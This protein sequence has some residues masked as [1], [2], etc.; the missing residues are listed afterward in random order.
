MALRVACAKKYKQ[1]HGQTRQTWLGA[2][3]SCRETEVR[4]VKQEAHNLPLVNL[5]VGMPVNIGSRGSYAIDKLAAVSM[6]LPDDEVLLGSERGKIVRL[7]ASAI[8]VGV[9]GWLGV[10]VCERHMCA[11]TRYVVGICVCTCVISK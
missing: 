3:C 6:V 1:M 8:E 10:R 2:G 9:G 7:L 5:Q 11:F 4:Q